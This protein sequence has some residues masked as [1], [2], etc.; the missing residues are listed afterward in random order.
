M[1]E[2]KPDATGGIVGGSDPFFLAARP[3][4]VHSG[5]TEGLFPLKEHLHELSL[6]D[7]MMRDGAR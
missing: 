2:G 7:L 6:S 3:A 5:M 1:G 4:G